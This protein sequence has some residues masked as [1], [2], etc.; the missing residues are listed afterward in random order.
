MNYI[1]N[2]KIFIYFGIIVICIYISNL[3]GINLNIFY[4]TIIAFIIILI[5]VVLG[6]KKTNNIKKD[7]II[8]DNEKIINYNDISFLIFS[9]ADL[10][11]YNIVSYNEMLNR[12]YYFFEIYDMS[13]IDEKNMGKYIEIN[14]KNKSLILNH[15]QSFIYKIPLN[16]ITRLKNIIKDFDTVLIQ[17]LTI[18]YNDYEKYIYYN[19][20]NIN[21]K[22]FNNLKKPFNYY[23]TNNFDIY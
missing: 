18:M 3:I 5:I 4:G 7:I 23:Q 12:I 11:M 14:I 6:N 1:N 17:Y 22:F 13:K 21:T 20:I 19:G 16:E 10:K 9:I 15:I 8:P 2:K